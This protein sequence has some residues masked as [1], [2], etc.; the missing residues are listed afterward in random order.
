MECDPETGAC[1][2]PDAE[3][4]RD[5]TATS[6]QAQVYYVGDPMCS[7]CWGMSPEI[8]VLAAHCVEQGLGFRLVMGGLRAGGGD[9]WNAA[10]RDFLRQEWTHIAARTGQPFGFRLLERSAFSYDTEP[11]CRAV[12][13]A[14]ELFGEAPDASHRELAFFAAVQRK[15]YVE[16]EDPKEPG[17]YRDICTATGLD[18]AEFEK[19]FSSPEA[20]AATQREFQLAR[21]LG[22]R[23]FPTVMLQTTAG[24]HEI[25]VGYASFATLSNRISNLKVT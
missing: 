17:F 15:I 8:E 14:R 16:G 23:G 24:L 11:A 20:V 22:V 12:V 9:P 2:L 6:T 19:S 3:T 18:P 25:S 10:F 13:T 1:L 7:W 21:Q 5:E 4:A